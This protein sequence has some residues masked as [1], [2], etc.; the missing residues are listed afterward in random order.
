MLFRSGSTA[1]AQPPVQAGNFSPKAS[2]AWQ[3]APEWTTKLNYGQAVRY[4]TVTEHYQIVSVGATNVVPNPNLLPETAQSFEWSI[5]RRDRRTMARL[6]LFAEDTAN[7]LISQT[8]TINNTPTTNFQNVGLIRNRTA[9]HPEGMER[10]IL[11]GDPSREMGSVAEP[12]CRR[13]QGALDLA[14]AR[15]VPVDWFAI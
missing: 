2:V 3:F 11:L 7:A 6:S 5:E 4:P 13:I 14:E 8:S 10:V 9:K 15:G 1:V 12:E